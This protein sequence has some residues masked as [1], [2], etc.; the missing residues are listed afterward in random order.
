[1]AHHLI[2]EF[3]LLRSTIKQP[4]YTQV[5]RKNFWA[6]VVKV[7]PVDGMV[8]LPLARSSN[9]IK[10]RK[11]AGV[12][13]TLDVIN[14]IPSWLTDVVELNMTRL[15]EMSHSGS[16][17]PEDHL[18]LAVFYRNLGSFLPKHF[19]HRRRLEINLD[20]MNICDAN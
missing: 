20:W 5:S 12:A 18:T 1:M 19:L 3:T 8:Q 13:S 16:V 9:K 14:Q 15:H 10:Q 6:E 11:S 4:I 7:E 17:V 2:I